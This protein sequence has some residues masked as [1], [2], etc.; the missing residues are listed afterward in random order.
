MADENATPKN[1]DRSIRELYETVNELRVEI[2][3][4]ATAFDGYAKHT[5]ILIEQLAHRIDTGRPNLLAVASV[6]I[7][8]AVL[9][10]KLFV[11]STDGQIQPIK[12]DIKHLEELA[13]LRATVRDQE[14]ATRWTARDREIELR[15]Q[16][17]ALSHGQMVKRLEII[18]ERLSSRYSDNDDAQDAKLQGLQKEIDMIRGKQ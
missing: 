8:F 15:D 10:G 13:T 17:N 9:V 14:I 18:E 4:N 11:V 2:R 5:T 16:I 6:L 12:N 1:G 3:E 7:A